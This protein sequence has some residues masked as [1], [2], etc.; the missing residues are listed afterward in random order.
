MTVQGRLFKC[1]TTSNIRSIDKDPGCGVSYRGTVDGLS[2]SSRKRLFDLFATLDLSGHKV[3]FVTLTYPE[4]FPSGIDS[5]RNLKALLK[6]F[7][8]RWPECSGVWRLELQQ[9]GA[10]HYHLLLFNL[11]YVPHGTL[12]EWWG[13]IIEYSDPIVRIELVKDR[14]IMVYLCKY[15]AKREKTE[16][17][18]PS[19]PLC[20]TVKETKRGREH[21]GRMWGC[22]NR[23]HLPFAP[24]TSLAVTHGRWY[25]TLKS[26]SKEVY[27]GIDEWAPDGFSVYHDDPIQLLNAVFRTHP[28]IAE[29]IIQS[30]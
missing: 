7:K 26:L 5:K 9:R 22:Y 13:D 17:A 23:Q 12:R 20:D 15:V 21:T 3:V 1:V 16:D 24:L 6:R 30:L 18:E 2:R 19:G 14:K 8:R 27:D 28:E 29:L 25:H 11:P 4:F 10:P